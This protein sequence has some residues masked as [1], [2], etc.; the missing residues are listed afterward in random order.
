MLL[1]LYSTEPVSP[2]L[3]VEVVIPLGM[4]VTAA[5]RPVEPCVQQR[6]Q[7]YHEQ[8]QRAEHPRLPRMSYALMPY[9]LLIAGRHLAD[10]GVVP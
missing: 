6:G 3:G 9:G 7:A 8:V 4:P 1:S 5:Y 10:I 2:L